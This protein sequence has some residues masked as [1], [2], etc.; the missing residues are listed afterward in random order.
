MSEGE[1]TVLSTPPAIK[2]PVD[3]AVLAH[4]EFRD[5]EYWRAIPAYAGL[6]ADEFHDHRFQSRNSVT[7]LKKLHH[8]LGDVVPD[9]FYQ[10]VEKGLSLSP[11]S[12]RISPYLMSLIDWSE[13]AT[14]PLRI[15][16]LP[17]GS[18]MLPDHPELSLD[19]LHEQEDSPVPGL[20]H[21]YADRALFL[22]LDTCPVYCRF[23]TRS[24]AV[25]LDTEEVEKVHF[26]A[27]VERWQQ[28][29]SYIES[30]PELEDIV[31]SGGD[32]A[33]L[34]SEHIEY[35]GDRLLNI[36]HVRRM[37]FATKAPAIMPQ[38]LVTDLEWVDALTRVVDKGRKIHKEVVLHTH[39]NHPREITDISR[40]GLNELMARGITVRNQ[41]VLQRGVNDDVDTMH[42][43]IRRLSYVNVHPYYT[44]V[45]DMVRGVEE[46]RTTLASAVD[47]EKKVRGC[48]AGFNTP[49][50]VLDTMGGGGKRN[51]HS[52]EHYDRETGI[53]VFTSPSVRP[54]A[55]FFYFD[56]IDQLNPDS[57]ERWV[58][59]L[60]RE[61]MLKAALDSVRS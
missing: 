17:M 9:S 58:N 26:G 40:R 53:A 43:L 61:N 11:M 41:M 10:D 46:L 32:V 42:L 20:T 44:F 47:L 2:P 16:F 28:V 54:G 51:V 34:K 48:T 38:K 45:H 23:C 50:F 35:I 18:R 33:N 30:R 31:I 24:Y 36:E 13:P 7:S 37:R 21:R 14:D 29:F 49:T 25:G 55:Y 6:P 59:P 60:E 1:K 19:S 15:Q 56:P 4:K 27:I 8:T 5:D 3:L 22:T 57:A 39:F 52:F 12:L